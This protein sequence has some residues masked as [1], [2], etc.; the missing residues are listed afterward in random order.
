VRAWTSAST[1]MLINGDRLRVEQGPDGRTAVAEMS[2]HDGLFTLSV[3][4]VTEEIPGDALPYLGHGLARSL[5]N[6]A[7]LRRAEAHGRLPVRVTFHGARPVLPGVIVTSWGNGSAEGY[8]T[9]GSAGTF[10]AALTRQ[11]RLDQASGRY[12]TDGLFAGNTTIALAGARPAPARPAIRSAGPKYTVTVTGTN[13]SGKPDSG[14]EL[15]LIDAENVNNNYSATFNDGSAEFSVP[16]STYWVIAGFESDDQQA[17]GGPVMRPG[18]SGS[19]RCRSS[20]PSAGCGAT[21]ARR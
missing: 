2:G 21:P 10:G 9:T 14:D 1:V 11:A 18:R 12:G 8:L 7:L 15:I 13:L 20:R 19:I 16:A 3:G 4:G 5:F 6:V 17:R